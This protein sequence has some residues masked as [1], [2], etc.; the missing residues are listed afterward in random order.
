MVIPW[1]PARS[2]RVLSAPEIDNIFRGSDDGVS[3]SRGES[4]NVCGKRI[5]VL[6]NYEL[7]A[8]RWPA[9]P[10]LPS[11]DAIT[12]ALTIPTPAIYSV[13]AGSAILLHA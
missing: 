10:K 12:S 8:L 7:G 1:C 2:R 13:N 4:V 6:S 3:P 5:E 9:N 11:V